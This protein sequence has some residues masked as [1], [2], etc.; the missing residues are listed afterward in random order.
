MLPVFAFF[1]IYYPP[2]W[3]CPRLDLPREDS[4]SPDGICFIESTPLAP[5]LGTL[6]LFLIA[7]QIPNA[8]TYWLLQIPIHISDSDIGPI[9]AALPID[10]QLSRRNR[11]MSSA[12]LYPIRLWPT[13]HLLNY[14]NQRSTSITFP[15]NHQITYSFGNN[16]SRKLP[17][18]K[19]QSNIKN[20]V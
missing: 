17:N 18:P 20:N 4:S 19:F 9:K 16:S 6:Y 11:K 14:L 3:R 8:G 2:W 5:D 10:K 1:D 13:T 12:F 15:Q 7:R